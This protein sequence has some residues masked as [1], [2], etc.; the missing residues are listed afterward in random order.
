MFQIISLLLHPNHI[1]KNRAYLNVIRRVPTVV[2][3]YASISLPKMLMHIMQVLR[4][5]RLCNIT[6]L[7]RYI[8]FLL[9]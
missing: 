7:L 4:W 9:R 2:V 6:A 3:L 5:Q 1:L 8:I